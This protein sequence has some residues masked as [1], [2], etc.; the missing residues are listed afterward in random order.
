MPFSRGG[1]PGLKTIR[2]EDV[3]GDAARFAARGSNVSTELDFTW[4][5][6]RNWSLLANA[7]Y[8]KNDSNNTINTY[9]RKQFSVAFHYEMK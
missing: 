2:V 7:S 3:V 5:L 1:E 4:L 8:I 9:D 6:S